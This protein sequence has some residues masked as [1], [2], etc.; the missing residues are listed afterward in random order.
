MR[1]ENIIRLLAVREPSGAVGVFGGATRF[2]K[3]V[4]AGAEGAG[5][6]WEDAVGQAGTSFYSLCVILVALQENVSLSSRIR[7][8]RIGS[9]KLFTREVRKLMAFRR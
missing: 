2:G 5:L 3:G 6:G 1:R 4:M 7:T 9:T 8:G